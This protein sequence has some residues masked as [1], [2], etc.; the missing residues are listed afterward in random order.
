MKRVVISKLLTVFLFVTTGC[1]ITIPIA[2]DGS[3]VLPVNP[4]NAEIMAIAVNQTGE[5]TTLEFYGCSD[6]MKLL[7]IISDYT[8][9]SVP[10]SGTKRIQPDKP[11]LIVTY[12]SDGTPYSITLQDQYLIM[13][14][15]N[16]DYD[17]PLDY[18]KTNYYKTAGKIPWD[19]IESI[20]YTP[21]DPYPSDPYLRTPQLQLV[22]ESSEPVLVPRIMV[23][24]TAEHIPGFTGF[25][26]NPAYGELNDI[27]DET[28]TMEFSAEPLEYTV[29]YYS[30]ELLDS[31]NNDD[32]PRMPGVNDYEKPVTYTDKDLADNTLPAAGGRY[33]VT[34]KF[35]SDVVL[36]EKYQKTID[37]I[38][39]FTAPGV[40][41][42]NDGINEMEYRFEINKP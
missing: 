28:V 2:A 6:E 15:Y 5:Q 16:P 21:A 38:M 23:N 18:Q 36:E 22:F 37:L 4:E 42:D 41:S 9:E 40:K 24:G 32:K 26:Y 1:S 7:G 30:W 10:L 12:V 3:F 27:K 29:V 25:I 19:D 13:H 35:N 8:C 14:E 31:Y 17:N 39:F 34:A 20:L 33:I 11:A